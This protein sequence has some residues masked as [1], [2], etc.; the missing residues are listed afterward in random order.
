MSVNENTLVINFKGTYSNDSYRSLLKDLLGSGLG[1][2]F[3]GRKTKI[4]GKKIDEKHRQIT[5]GYDGAR[6]NPLD[7]DYAFQIA[8]IALPSLSTPRVTR[9]QSES[10]AVQTYNIEA[11]F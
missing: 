4:D 5:V 3:D 1:Q 8:T 10:P 2:V 11:Y 7:L 9:E 6:I